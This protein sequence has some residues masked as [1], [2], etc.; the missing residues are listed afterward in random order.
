MPHSGRIKKIVVDGLFSISVFKFIQEVEDELVKLGMIDEKEL[1]KFKEHLEKKKKKK[2]EEIKK[3]KIIRFL[4]KNQSVK[5]FKLVKFE[6]KLNEEDYPQLN[7]NPKI[8]SSILIDE[9]KREGLAFKHPDI[10][11]FGLIF[12]LLHQN[13]LEL[14][15]GDIINIKTSDVIPSLQLTFFDNSENMLF[16][17]PG[18]QRE[19]NDIINKKF[20]GMFSYLFTFLIELD[21][22]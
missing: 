12:R 11:G 1:S 19:A 20:I 7:T 16:F 6:K 5:P 18:K 3:E 9:F 2:R 15:E 13:D 10:I 14:L 4:P 8:I 21:P 17:K 22:L